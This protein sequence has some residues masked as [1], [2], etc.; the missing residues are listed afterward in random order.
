MSTIHGIITVG[1]AIPTMKPVGRTTLVIEQRQLQ[2]ADLFKMP[3]D[4]R[5]EF[6]DGD[7]ET[8]VVWSETSSGHLL[9]PFRT[10]RC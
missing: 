7:S 5:L 9:H 10:T 3:V 4:V 8:R 6:E 1:R 2:L